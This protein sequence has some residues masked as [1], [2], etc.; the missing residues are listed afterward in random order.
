MQI[1]RPERPREAEVN[2]RLEEAPAYELVIALAAAAHP[3]KHHLSSAW[4]RQVRSALPATCRSDLSFFF[5]DPAAL[6]VGGIQLIPR[7]SSGDVETFLTALDSIDSADLMAA[8]LGRRSEIR[9]L[10]GAIRRVARGRG[11]TPADEE[12]IRRHVAS[13]R[14]TSR[15]RFREIM[16]GPG[17]S[18]D[19]Y[20]RLL[21]AFHERVFAEH[22]RTIAPFVQL[23][24]KQGR[25]NIGKLPT[26]EV[27]ARVT[28][29]F[30]LQSPGAGSIVLV[31]SY[32]AA[33]FVYAVESGRET[34]VVFGVRPAQEDVTGGPVDAQT[35]RVLKALADETRLRILQLL[36]QRP[37]YGQQIAEALGV[38]HP[39]VS[40]HMALLRIA[41]LT[42]TELADDGNKTYSVRPEAIEELSSV[43]HRTFTGPDVRQGMR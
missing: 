3:A 31:P 22:Y 38:S 24:A 11:A 9:A 36:S 8:M 25:R 17:T 10:P 20:V 16:S 35:V 26:K 42:R 33:P 41:G 30:T 12:T 21:H 14:A 19:R 27:I 28:G 34:V 37:L 1:V 29:G 39:T 15:T 43:L 18:R 23:R 6:G 7:L 13:L 40:H 5:G 32:Y 4:S 2:L